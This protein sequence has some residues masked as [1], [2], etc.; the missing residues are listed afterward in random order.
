MGT[1]ALNFPVGTLEDQSLSTSRALSV[2]SSSRDNSFRC[3]AFANGEINILVSSMYVLLPLAGML[4]R[5]FSAD[6]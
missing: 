6:S 4:A 5:V 3:R 2:P 1:T